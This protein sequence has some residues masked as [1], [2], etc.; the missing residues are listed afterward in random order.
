[1]Q[2]C[3]RFLPS[4]LVMFLERTTWRMSRPANPQAQPQQRYTVFSSIL[5]VG[6]TTLP[7]SSFHKTLFFRFQ[8]KKSEA[9]L[10]M[11]R[12]DHILNRIFFIN[13]VF[14]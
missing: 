1:M 5:C 10:M 6:T 13:Y 2:W 7:P 12:D 4:I 11:G 9:P 8:K 14:H 3:V